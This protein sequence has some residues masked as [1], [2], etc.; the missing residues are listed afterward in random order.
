MC[1][2]IGRKMA[3]PFLTW[4]QAH[5][6]WPTGVLGTVFLLAFLASAFTEWIGVHAI[7]GAFLAGVLF[8]D[9]GRLRGRT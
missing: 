8:A 3:A 9:T 5:G 4:V 2:T 1:L 6:G 7:F